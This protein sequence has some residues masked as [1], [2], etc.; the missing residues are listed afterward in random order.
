M[1]AELT[2]KPCDCLHVFEPSSVK[3]ALQ[4]TWCG[5]EVTWKEIEQIETQ[6]AMEQWKRFG[7]NRRE[8][9][10]I[11]YQLGAKRHVARPEHLEQWIERAT[12][13]FLFEG[14]DYARYEDSE[15]DIKVE[16]TRL[17]PKLSEKSRTKIERVFKNL[18]L[19]ASYQEERRVIGELFKNILNQYDTLICGLGTKS[20]CRLLFN[21]LIYISDNREL[22]K[23]FEL[24]ID[25]YEL[26]ELE[27][28]TKCIKP[29]LT[30]GNRDK[31][32]LALIRINAVRENQSQYDQFKEKIKALQIENFI[33]RRKNND[34]QK[35]QFFNI[36]TV[37]AATL[38]V[39]AIGAL[40]VLGIGISTWRKGRDLH[41]QS[42]HMHEKALNVYKRATEILKSQALEKAP[43]LPDPA[44]I[45]SELKM[46]SE[47]ARV[48]ISVITQIAYAV[49][50]FFQYI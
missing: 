49:R 16:L 10:I 21:N 28:F 18:Q 17:L 1:S 3:E 27:K 20:Y 15:E 24:F 39:C 36:T 9:S 19:V 34:L 6:K 45:N 14:L 30:I 47:K 4:C 22:D 46:P 26:E 35:G 32:D 38:G 48:I 41:D 37:S 5:K 29:G 13:T 44:P 33:L 50:I 40:I 42:Y 7:Q 12:P 25:K 23:F 8:S 2:R 11:P 31:L 43:T